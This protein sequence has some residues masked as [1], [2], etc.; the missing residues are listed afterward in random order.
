MNVEVDMTM[1][2]KN[3]LLKSDISP[4][5]SWKIISCPSCS[6]Y[7]EFKERHQVSRLGGNNIQADSRG[8]SYQS[9][10]IHE[11]LLLKTKKKHGITQY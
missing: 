11:H 10:K 6:V 5:V 3:V 8:L 9:A 2:M 4:Y 7:M 1:R